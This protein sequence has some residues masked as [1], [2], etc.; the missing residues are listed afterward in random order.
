VHV[1]PSGADHVGA[2]QATAVSAATASTT[3]NGNQI[4]A[5]RKARLQVMF[6]VIFCHGCNACPP[7]VCCVMSCRKAHTRVTFKQS[8][9]VGA[10]AD[11]L[12]PC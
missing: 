7:T 12:V 1:Q 8:V 5:G 9:V 11:T 2:D 6:V 3:S 10:R 4:H